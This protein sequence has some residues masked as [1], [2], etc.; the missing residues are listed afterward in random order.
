MAKPGS[1]NATTA[2]ASLDAE[3]RAM[4]YEGANLSQL[5]TLF[6]M[7]HRVLVEKLHG[8]AP[9]GKR[10]SADIYNVAEVAPKLVRP[11][12]DIETYIKRMNPADLPKGV[13]KEFWAGMRSKQ[14]Y[15]LKNGQLWP[16][17]E[18]VEKVGELFKLMR[19][20][21]RLLKDTVARQVD[22]TPRQRQIIRDS[23]DGALEDLRKKIVEHFSYESQEESADSEL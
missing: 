9:C 2:G 10:G 5:S 3:S 1:K 23:A 13:S 8:V 17:T 6:R 22:L 16:T 19:M 11:D 14:E 15:E 12:Y 7:D 20:S 21:L 18:V 4:L